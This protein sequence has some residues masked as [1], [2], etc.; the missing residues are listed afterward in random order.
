MFFGHQFH[1]PAEPFVIGTAKNMV[2]LLL[3]QGKSVVID[4][5]GLLYQFRREWCN[6]GNEFEATYEIVWFRASAV[7]CLKR[8]KKRPEGTR[9]PDEVITRMNNQL[10]SPRDWE[11]FY[12]GFNKTKITEVK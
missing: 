11:Y 5:T 8:N 9:V 12:D 4:S 3:K 7:T 10:Q 2:R 1:A 6:I